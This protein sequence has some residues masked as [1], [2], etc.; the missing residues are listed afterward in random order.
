M[1]NI[2]PA[3]RSIYR[4][5]ALRTIQRR[6]PYLSDKD[7]EVKTN[8]QLAKHP[9]EKDIQVAIQLI[10]RFAPIAD[11][12][13]GVDSF[14]NKI[15]EQD[16]ENTGRNR[17]MKLLKSFGV[18][19]T[20]DENRLQQGLP[21]VLYL[22]KV[23][24]EEIKAQLKSQRVVIRRGKQVVD[25]SGKQVA[26]PDLG[27]HGLSRKRTLNQVSSND[28]GLIVKEEAMVLQTPLEEK[29]LDEQLVTLKELIEHE[30]SELL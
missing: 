29:I 5:K 12:L 6:Y 8:E 28:T 14:L 16:P 22:A 18:D 25:G 21:L 17:L 13:S 4:L 3:L 30:I 11:R 2:L 10:N 27:L 1:I 15:N 26:L 7:R 19:V 23:F 24:P 20:P 9:V